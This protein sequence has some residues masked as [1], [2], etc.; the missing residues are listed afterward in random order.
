MSNVSD[1]RNIKISKTG[2]QIDE[3]MMKDEDK[4]LGEQN[5]KRD[6][7]DFIKTEFP[8]FQEYSNFVSFKRMKRHDRCLPKISR[9]V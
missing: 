5:Y 1:Y 7:D 9:N 2:Y 8:N 6:H 3:E 4:E